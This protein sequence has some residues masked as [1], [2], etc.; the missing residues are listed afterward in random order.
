MK[1]IRRKVLSARESLR[2]RMWLLRLD[3]GHEND[4]YL[5]AGRVPKTRRCTA[6]ERAATPTSP[7]PEG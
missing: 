7:T 1:H 5:R 6:C 2:W 3:C 4:G